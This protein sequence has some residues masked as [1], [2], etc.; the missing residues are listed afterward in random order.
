MVVDFQGIPMPSM[1]G[2]FTHIWLFF[3]GNIWW[4]IGKYT[5]PM[6]PKAFG[7]YGCGSDTIFDRLLKWVL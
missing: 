5:S 2:I 1:Y 3:E 4:I 7:L 6:A